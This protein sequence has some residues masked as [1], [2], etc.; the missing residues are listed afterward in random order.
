MR[1]S[2]EFRKDLKEYR[3]WQGWPKQERNGIPVDEL[4][5]FFLRYHREIAA[6]KNLANVIDPTA[7]NLPT[8]GN[9]KVISQGNLGDGELRSEVGGQRSEHLVNVNTQAA[10]AKALRAYYGNRI[11]ITIDDEIVSRW[12]KGERLPNE[13][14]PLPPPKMAGTNYWSA[15]EWAAWIDKWILP[16]FL[17]GVVAQGELIP[18]ARLE[19]MR[20]TNELAELEHAAFQRDLERNAYVKRDVALA[21]VRAAL[22]KM[23]ALVQRALEVDDT[24][25]RAT[26]LLGLPGLT[27]EA[28]QSFKEF[29]T[30]LARSRMDAME[31]EYETAGKQAKIET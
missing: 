7:F 31:T 2:P 11:T 6:R 27:P 16:H 26:F 30:R 29:D 18:T 10:L 23:H 15:A 1:F 12:R 17:P 5:A 22:R 13:Q 8:A 21:T 14:V 19:Q 3:L 25:A 28:V 4:K 20:V 24:A 9:L